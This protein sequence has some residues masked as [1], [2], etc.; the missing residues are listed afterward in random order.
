ML[1]FL[2]KTN[3][4]REKKLWRKLEN[5]LVYLRVFDF[6]GHEIFKI[7]ELFDIHMLKLPLYEWY[8]NVQLKSLYMQLH[9]RN[10]DTCNWSWYMHL[11][12]YF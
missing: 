8:Y 9:N 11:K 7:I 6:F 1:K 4:P 2:K 5:L 3:C 10:V 12:K